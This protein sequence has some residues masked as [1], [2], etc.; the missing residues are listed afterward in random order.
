MP[1]GVGFFAR[2]PAGYRDVRFHLVFFSAPAHAVQALLPEPLHSPTGECVAAGLDVPESAYGA[3]QEAFLLMKCAFRDQ[4]GWFCS[5]VFHNGPAGIAAGREIYGTPK[6]YSRITADLE[7]EALS[8]EVALNTPVMRIG[9]TVG[10]PAS[11]ALLPPLAPSWRLK[12]IPR[13]DGAGLDVK[14]LVD[15][16]ATAHDQELHRF[17]EATGAVEFFPHPRFDLTPLQPVSSGPSFYMRISYTEHFGVIVHDY[18]RDG[19]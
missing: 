1:H 10:P 14:Q 19:R 9:G 6:I 16:G 4:T 15:C 13:A 8:T 17:A 12:V 11:P 18:L 2:P 7:G 3:F 5:H